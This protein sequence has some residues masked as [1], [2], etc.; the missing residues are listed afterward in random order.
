MLVCPLL[1]ETTFYKTDF[2]N[3]DLLRRL[4][5]R[6]VL[7]VALNPVSD[8]DDGIMSFLFF[9]VHIRLS[10]EL[11]PLLRNIYVCIVLLRVLEIVSA[12]Y[13]HLQIVLDVPRILILLV[14][15]PELCPVNGLLKL[16]LFLRHRLHGRR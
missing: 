15:L 2:V 7:S 4:P 8:V 16:P 14:R 6:R 9:S 11:M 12:V 10:Y 1:R 3:R 5:L 13:Y